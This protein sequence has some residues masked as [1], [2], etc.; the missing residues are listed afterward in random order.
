[1]L[2]FAHLIEENM[3]SVKYY[4]ERNLKF[5]EKYFSKSDVE[6]GFANYNLAVYYLERSNSNLSIPYFEK[7][8]KNFN[9]SLKANHLNLGIL[10]YKYA[11][12]LHGIGQ[13][14]R[15]LSKY[16]ESINIFK[17]NENYQQLIYVYNNLATMETYLGK[18]ANS[19]AY[20]DEAI[21]L[22]KKYELYEY[23]LKVY[24]LQGLV[25]Y[26]SNYTENYQKAINYQVEILND[27]EN[28]SEVPDKILGKVYFNLSY[29]YNL[30]SDTS[31]TLK[32]LLLAQNFTKPNTLASANLKSEM[33]LYYQ[34][35]GFYDKSL[36]EFSISKAW[37]E[38]NLGPKHDYVALNYQ[39]M[40]KNFESLGEKSKA[41]SIIIKGSDH[42]YLNG[43]DQLAFI[44]SAHMGL[45]SQRIKIELDKSKNNKDFESLIKSL[46]KI[47]FNSVFKRSQI[48]DKKDITNY[49]ENI[50]DINRNLIFHLTPVFNK[51]NSHIIGDELLRSCHRLRS[52]GLSANVDEEKYLKSQ[53]VSEKIFNE[54]IV[55]RNKARFL[56]L[57]RND[58]DN[59]NF[60][61]YNKEVELLNSELSKWQSKVDLS[62]MSRLN[63]ENNF[64]AYRKALCKNNRT[65]VLYFIHM[66]KYYAFVVNCNDTKI[67]QIGNK[68]IID[69]IV[70]NLNDNILKLLPIDK[71]MPMSKT[72]Y[73]FLI[74]PIKECLTN[75]VT[76]IP[77]G[78]LY[79]L[80][81]E[82][83]IDS[84]IDRHN[85]LVF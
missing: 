18:Y 80:N 83:L 38:K 66:D 21:K 75:N 78:A 36:I 76:I 39:Q 26:E 29:L 9:V 81:F 10:S 85:R 35:A 68:V 69:D 6:Y 40:A 70:K 16:N 54:Y 15:A 53:G 61:K 23:P 56:E 37:Y 43:Y 8:E 24:L 4:N 65:I 60:E 77:D 34:N 12:A 47:N 62:K 67:I 28:Q 45:L 41:D 1:M 51:H 72:V 27:I 44:P 19:K 5:I 79:T 74:Q 11:D 30:K 49:I 31:Q 84:K 7:A 32:Y 3:D 52:A 64:V 57:Q 33:G 14:D 2:S 63:I 71:L 55:L 25:S 46:S 50:S 58:D 22:A 17:I 59:L 82:V 20:I 42:Y 48:V 13:Y 73:N